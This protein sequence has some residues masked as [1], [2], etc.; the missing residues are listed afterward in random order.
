MFYHI[1]LFK[2][3]AVYFFMESAFS[4][5]YGISKFHEFH[6]SSTD[7]SFMKEMFK[8][9]NSER[10]NVRKYKDLLDEVFEQQK[11]LVSGFE[12]SYAVEKKYY[13][14]KISK[15]NSKSGELEKKVSEH[16]NNFNDL[17]KNIGEEENVLEKYSVICSEILKEREE[18]EFDRIWLRAEENSGFNSSDWGSAKI[19]L[20]RFV[21]YNI[22]SPE[23]SLVAFSDFNHN[24]EMV[25]SK[26]S[27]SDLNEA[28]EDTHSDKEYSFDYS[29]K[30]DLKSIFYGKVS[31]VGA[32]I[33]EAKEYFDNIYVV[34]RA[35][36]QKENENFNMNREEDDFMIVGKREG[37]D[38]LYLIGEKVRD[39]VNS[40]GKFRREDFMDSPGEIHFG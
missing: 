6:D 31:D 8:K 37:V 28:Y 21:F 16:V 39:E 13:E 23:V 26:V 22:D 4:E 20:P 11:T 3:S 25:H 10:A 36:W 17:N 2:V 38:R 40:K 9:Q 5:K 29:A 15:T 34:A 18:K 14:S 32:K 7:Y 1:N 24:G 35:N 30:M 33:D 19:N 12:G 27:T